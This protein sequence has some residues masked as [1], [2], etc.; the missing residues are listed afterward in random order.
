[1]KNEK[2]LAITKLNATNGSRNIPFQNKEFEQDGHPHFEGFQPH[3]NINMM[4]QMQSC[5]IM[6]NESA[7]SQESSI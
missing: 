6:K 2:K 3:F 7:I 4:S 5:K 1:M